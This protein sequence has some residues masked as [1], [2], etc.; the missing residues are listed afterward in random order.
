MAKFRQPPNSA[1]EA[2]IISKSITANGTYNASAD[3]ADGYNPVTVA[4]PIKTIVSK[5][6]TAN[7]TYNASAD[8]ADGY[9]PVIVNVPTGVP[10]ISRSDW[11]NLTTE[12]KQAL[13]EIAIQDAST[14]FDRG[15]L[16]YGADYTPIGQYIPNTP[17]ANVICEAVAGDFISSKHE[18]GRGST[19]IRFDY[20]PGYDSVQ[21]DSTEDALYCPVSSSSTIPY[22]DLGASGTPFTAYVVAKLVSPGQY[23]R[24]ISCMNIRSAGNGIMLVGNPLTVSAWADDTGINVASNS[25]FAGVIQYGGNGSAKGGAYGANLVSKSPSTCGRFICLG[26]T[27]LN[28]DINNAEAVN[29]YVKYIAVTNSVDSESVINNNLTNLALEFLQ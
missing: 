11:N 10:K 29:M 24:A 21:Y 18:W 7:G 26:R 22:C 14:G 17:E 15:I 4:V 12:E 28:H 25:Y 23:S 6:I 16:A 20:A 27:D 9:D 5:T 8:S 3:N 19:P 13:G 1:A 2:T